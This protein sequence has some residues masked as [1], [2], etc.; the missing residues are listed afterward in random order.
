MVHLCMTAKKKGEETE[1]KTASNASGT[2]KVNAGIP[3]WLKKK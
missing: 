3:I 2:T 1:K